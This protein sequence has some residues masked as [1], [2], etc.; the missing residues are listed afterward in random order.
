MMDVEYHES[1][2][3]QSEPAYKTA[4]H[5]KMDLETAHHREMIAELAKKVDSNLLLEKPSASIIN[6]QQVAVDTL[7]K[8]LEFYFGNP[9]LHKDC[10]MRD[11]IAKHAKGYVDLKDILGFKRVS[12]ILSMYHMV[13]YDDRLE[14]LC[15][16]ADASNILKLCKQRLRVK[17]R[18]ALDTNVIGQ[19]EYTAEVDSRTIYVENIPIYATHETV[20]QVFQKH[21]HILLVSMPRDSEAK[22]QNK[23]KGFAFVEFEVGYI[24]A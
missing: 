1:A 5:E 19:P 20:A 3:K 6:N 14:M 2:D 24:L 16:A 13:K 7:K 21:G 11:L 18:V 15:Q 12:Q 22:S 23:N 9:N 17:R 10:H 4:T 8:Q